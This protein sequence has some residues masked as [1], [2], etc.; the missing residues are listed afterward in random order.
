MSKIGGERSSVQNPLID[1]VKEP[2]SEY[3][4]DSGRHIIYNLGW[5][6][7]STE[8]AQRLR[9]GI[10]GIILR[11]TFV[12]QIQKLNPEVIDNLHAEGLITLLE[13]IPPNIHGNKT[14]WEWLSGRQSIYI[15]REKRNRNVILI[16]AENIERN[17]FHVTDELTFTNGSK[18]IRMDVVFY[19]NGFPVIV[20]ETKAAHKIDG[21]DDALEQIKRYH[22]DCPEILAILQV[23]SLTHLIHYFYSATWNLKQK[24]I[25]NWKEEA[26]GNFENLVKSFFDKERIIK[27]LT[28]YILFI[29]QEDELRKIVL[30]PHQ[31]RAIEKLIERTRESEKKRALIWHTQGSGKTYT[32]IVTAQKIISNPAFEN[33]TVLMLIDRNEL[34]SQLKDNLISAGFENVEVADSKNHIR[35]LFAKDRRGLIVSMIHKFDEIPANINTSENV[36]VLVDEAHRTTGGKLG[37]YLTG[38]LPKATYIGFTGTPIDKTAYGKGTFVV[39]GR[40]D[41]PHGYLDKYSI[42]ESIADGTT[43]KLNYAIAPNELKVDKEILEK[44]FL[45]LAEAEGVSDIEDLN[46]VLEKAVTLRTM[47]KKP[48]RIEGVAKYVAEHFKNNVEPMDYKAFMVGVDRESCA[49]YKEALDNYL[50]SEYSEVVYSPGHNDEPHLAKYHLSTE[51]EKQIRKEFKKPDSV[52]K[53]LIVTEKLLT[54]YDA[55][56]LYCMY[57]DKPMRD[58][59]LLQAIAR[60]NRPYEDNGGKKKPSGFVLDFVGIFDNL[61]KALA[62]DSRDVGEVVHDIE[63]LKD[64]F[65]DLMANAKRDYLSIIENKS[66]DKAVE[67]ILDYFIEEEERQAY[68]QFFRE[69]SDIYE[70]I[71][72]D[73]FLRPYIEDFE[74]LL[75]MYKILKEAY[76][77]GIKLRKEFSRKTEKL[78]QEHTESGKIK[79]SIETYEIDDLTLK[80]IEESQASDTEKIFN[81]LK[82]IQGTILGGRHES[83]YLISIGE[84]AAIIVELFKNR[85][86][87]TQ[88]TLENLKEIIAEINEARQEQK[89]RNMTADEFTVFWSLQKVGIEKAD[90]N[91]GKI[92]DVLEQFPH[93]RKSEQHEREV[94]QSFYSVL[95]QSGMKD[96]EKVKE[97]VELIIRALRGREL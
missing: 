87:N 47:L 33:P 80:K 92:R 36:F 52:P 97:L 7:I 75:R 69:M 76:D 42:S 6:Y 11:E 23:Y 10:E 34:E 60:V 55:P 20:V 51:K 54:G 77:P 3:T 15:Q 4:T 85:Q 62:F 71:S 26:F 79:A 44:E 29:T 21:M 39:F 89:S 90:E 43:V 59:V 8:E 67:A 14:A 68:Y 25:F 91:A 82:S 9:G 13:R 96:L 5:E 40:D 58:H 12:N 70:I 2:S 93:W 86:K 61:E 45:N 30:R 64:D 49:M 28:E 74:T 16:D 72:P 27:L 22:H 18:T 24:F 50:P 48:E 95:L 88:E 37:N 1:Y 63:K 41:A 57:L 65:A 17:T 35:E 78:V 53:I 56:I 81:L 66:R 73:P 46:K 38:A 84:K 94:K 19:I 32:M 31:M 83:P